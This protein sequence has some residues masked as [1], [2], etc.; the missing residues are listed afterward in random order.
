MDDTAE[1]GSQ[2]SQSKNKSMYKYGSLQNSNAPLNWKQRRERMDLYN[3]QK[4]F[5]FPE[6]R[7]LHID[8]LTK[9]AGNDSKGNRK[10]LYLK[11]VTTRN[12][13]ILKVEE[14]SRLEKEINYEDRW[15]LL[16]LR[17]SVQ[18]VRIYINMAA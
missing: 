8:D 1:Y 15:P 11:Q 3:M 16:N 2:M 12:D 17:K 14:Q 4:A 13:I 6:M 9:W 10:T 18:K 5:S 7:K